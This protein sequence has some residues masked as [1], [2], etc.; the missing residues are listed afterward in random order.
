MKILD[1]EYQASNLMAYICNSK[2]ERKQKNKQVAQHFN[3]LW[4]TDVIVANKCIIVVLQSFSLSQD[5]K[6]ELAK[7]YPWLIFED[8]TESDLMSYNLVN[9]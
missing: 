8:I 4:E 2:H 6:D 5:K 1:K 3:N 7:L 9:Y